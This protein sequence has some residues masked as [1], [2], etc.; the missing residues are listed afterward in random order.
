MLGAAGRGPMSTR[1]LLGQ[2]CG[3]EEPGRGPSTARATSMALKARDSASPHRLTAHPYPSS[4]EVEPYR[5]T[6]VLLW[7]CTDW[8]WPHREGPALVLPLPGR[9]PLTLLGL[10]SEHQWV[11]L[12]SLQPGQVRRAVI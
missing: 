7:L 9:A 1:R 4:D 2:M 3:P 8:D 5:W 10:L 6:W 11:L 12:S